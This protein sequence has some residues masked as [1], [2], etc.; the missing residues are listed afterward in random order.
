LIKYKD[1]RDNQLNRRGGLMDFQK[2]SIGLF[3]L[4]TIFTTIL[5][6]VIKEMIDNWGTKNLEITDFT[7]QVLFATSI[8]IV[9]IVIVCHIIMG[10]KIDYKIDL[11]REEFRDSSYYSFIQNQRE[12]HKLMAR[13]I[14]EAEKQIYILSDLASE[15]EKRKPEHKIYL[16]TLDDVL[17]N[18]PELKF[19]RIIVPALDP[20]KSTYSDEEIIKWIKSN[21]AY[22]DHFRTINQ[23]RKWCLIAL[24]HGGPLGFSIMLI[25][26]RYLFFVIE[27][28]FEDKLIAELLEGGF[29]FEN[30]GESLVNKI[31]QFFEDIMKKETL[32]VE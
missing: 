7:Q 23:F 31:Q 9:L 6:I 4:Y 18:K 13:R 12:R 3:I 19:L 11:I 32:V 27:E 15:Q 8:I 1:Y 14:E 28:K 16:Q 22:E 17:A 26:D 29:Y 21:R 10:K 5:G 24:K 2:K 30:L 25:D 20:Q